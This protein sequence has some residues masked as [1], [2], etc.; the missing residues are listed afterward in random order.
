M[1][2]YKLNSDEYLDEAIRKLTSMET[3]SEQKGKLL[4][5]VSIAIKSLIY[6]RKW[7]IYLSLAMLPLLLS[8]MVDDHLMGNPDGPAAFVDFLLGFFFFF[9]FTFGCLM[10]A[11]PLSADEVTDHV[12]DLYLVRPVRR[13]TMWISRWIVVNLAVFTINVL[14]STIYYIY[15]H[16]VD[17]NQSF[18]D[19]FVDNLVLL[20]A[21]YAF[22]AIATLTYAGLFLFVGFIGN[23]G[24]TLGMILALVEQFFLS[25]L[26]L[27]DNKWIPRTNLV[28]L[29]DKFFGTY[30][31]YDDYGTLPKGLSILESW[32]YL[33]VFT[34]VFLVVGARYLK[35]REFK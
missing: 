25:L 17:P 23:K 28:H 26:F 14:I 9:L 24:F 4:V 33:I 7:V 6:G 10:L 8:L 34:L 27:K 18:A 32:L 12:T 20:L 19:K 5:S 13:E 21:A 15:F 31:D 29:A 35:K 30:F 2:Q 3:V 16:L 22:F 11:L 1:E